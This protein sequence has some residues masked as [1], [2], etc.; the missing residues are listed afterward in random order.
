MRLPFF[1]HYV[2][3]HFTHIQDAFQPPLSLMEDYHRLNLR[4]KLFLCK[5]KF[6]D[7]PAW[8]TMQNAEAETVPIQDRPRTILSTDYYSEGLFKFLSAVIVD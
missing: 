4:N 6:G 8:P 7:C 2:I 3:S 5:G 1:Y